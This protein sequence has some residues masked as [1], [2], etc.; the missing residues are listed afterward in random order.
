MF[1]KLNI[2]A[3]KLSVN[4]LIMLPCKY[5]VNN[6]KVI[7]MIVESNNKKKKKRVKC[8]LVLNP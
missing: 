2:F 6:G 5:I 3:K 4:L 7:L 1:T 8:V